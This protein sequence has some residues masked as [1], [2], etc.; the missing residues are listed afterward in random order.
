MANDRME[1]IRRKAIERAKAGLTKQFAARD[2]LVI[3][4]VNTMDELDKGLNVFSERMREW[5]SAHFPELT[6]A[7]KD[8]QTYLRQVA[9]GSRDRMAD[10]KLRALAERSSGAKFREEDYTAMAVHADSLIL[11]YTERDKLTRYLEML[12]ESEAPN[13]NHILGTN[14]G[15]RMISLAGGLERLASLPA[16]TVQVLGA[17]KALF[18]HLRTGAPSPKYGVLY[19]LPVINKAPKKIQG[20]LSRTIAGKVSIAAKIDF[21]SKRFDAKLKDDLDRKLNR[22]RSR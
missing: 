11:L 22:I 8:H 7:V 9:R 18:R 19:Q 12:M 15:A 5:Y 4:T 16:S 3:Q 6:R 17:E 13:M 14:V 10:P 2:F 20:K 1:E 21:Y